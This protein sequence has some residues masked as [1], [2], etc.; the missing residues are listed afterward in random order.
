MKKSTRGIFATVLTAVLGLALLGGAA[1]A[2][3]APNRT[4]TAADHGPDT[5][6]LER[7]LDGLVDEGV[8]SAEQRDAILAKVAEAGHDDEDEESDEDEDGDEDENESDNGKNKRDLDPKLRFDV[9]RLIGGWQKAVMEYLGLDR[10]EVMERLRGGQTLADIADDLED[11]SAAGLIETLETLAFE[12]VDALVAAEKLTE[13]QGETAKERVTLAIEKVLDRAFPAK[14]RAER[15][16]KSERE[17]SGRENA[18][19]KP[20]HANPGKRP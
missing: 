9:H 17:N 20:A 5:T 16:P 14:P 8:L 4:T 3:F 11:K 12:K 6:R 1:A 10:K 15:A 7:V 2:A 13:A 19:K 18:G